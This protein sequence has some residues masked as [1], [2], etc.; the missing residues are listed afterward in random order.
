MRGSN[1]K[2]GDTDDC[3]YER[4]NP[5]FSGISHDSGFSHVT[6]TYDGVSQSGIVTMTGGGFVV[7]Q[8]EVIIENTTL[9]ADGVSTTNV[10]A[11]AKTA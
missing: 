4:H 3:K 11:Y 6:A 2:P 7:T 8:I 10:Y 9:N 1:H 5:D